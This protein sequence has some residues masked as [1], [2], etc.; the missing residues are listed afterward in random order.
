MG[1]VP[2]SKTS[3]ARRD[4]RRA[5][6]FRLGVPGLAEC[7]QCHKPK[8]SHRVCPNC[9]YYNGKEVVTVQE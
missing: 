1:A 7:P 6:S 2:K 5:N 8:L 4:S 9:G 3:K